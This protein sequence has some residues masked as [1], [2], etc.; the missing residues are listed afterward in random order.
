MNLESTKQSRSVF[1]SFKPFIASSELFVLGE[2]DCNPSYKTFFRLTVFPQQFHTWMVFNNCGVG[3]TLN[4]TADGNCLY[5]SISTAISGNEDLWKDIK[6]GIFHKKTSFLL[7]NQKDISNK[8]N[9]LFSSLCSS[10]EE[11]VENSSSI[12]VFGRSINL[13]AIS[14]LLMRAIYV[15]EIGP[16]K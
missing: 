9:F 1:S 7:T 5:H 13:F 2:K 15:Y 14:L 10:F 16:C 12:V 11:I 3:I 8:K 6:L 4:T